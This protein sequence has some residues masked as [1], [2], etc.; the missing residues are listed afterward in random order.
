MRDWKNSFFFSQ[1][2]TQL[3]DSTFLS[4][5]RDVKQGLGEQVRELLTL[6]LK[7]SSQIFK[8]LK[9][10]PQTLV[11][12]NTWN[13]LVLMK[14]S[15]QQTAASSSSF[16]WWSCLNTAAQG[17]CLS[18]C[19]PRPLAGIRPA[20]CLLTYWVWQ[21]QSTMN[22]FTFCQVGSNHRALEYENEG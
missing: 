2:L 17:P 9:V 8:G 3:D 19:P 7:K 1:K 12:W 5:C 14:I 11:W 21:N 13:H 15:P 18:L 4:I 6:V 16:L 22:P 20:L 10:Y